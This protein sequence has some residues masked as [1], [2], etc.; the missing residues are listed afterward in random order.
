MAVAALDRQSMYADAMRCS[1]TT[2]S[3]ADLRNATYPFPLCLTYSQ[4]SGVRTSIAG[5]RGVLA[6]QAASWPKG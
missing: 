4:P 5:E 3:L 1:M 6:T 2:C